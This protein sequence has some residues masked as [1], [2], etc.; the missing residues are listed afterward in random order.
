[1]SSF[2]QFFCQFLHNKNLVNPFRPFPIAD[3]FDWKIL[4]ISLYRE[5]VQRQKQANNITQTL[6]QFYYISFL[7]KYPLN[8]GYAWWFVI[9]R[10]YAVFVVCNPI[11]RSFWLDLWIGNAMTKANICD[12]DHQDNGVELEQWSGKM[13]KFIV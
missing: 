2:F 3:N 1:M 11:T 12:I 6:H 10:E 9:I 8:H 4:I 13:W 7:Q 5:I